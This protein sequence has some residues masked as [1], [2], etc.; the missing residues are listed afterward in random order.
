MTKRDGKV[1][2]KQAIIFLFARDEAS[3]FKIEDY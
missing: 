2:A 3:C 1:V